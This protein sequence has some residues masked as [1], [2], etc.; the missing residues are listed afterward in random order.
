MTK[1]AIATLRE[2]FHYDP[3]TGLITWRLNVNSRARAG[4]EAGCVSKTSTKTYRRIRFQ[5]RNYYGHQV[6]FAL[7]TGQWSDLIDHRDH[8]GLNNAWGNLRDATVA[9]NQHNRTGLQLNN[10]S[11][12]HGASVTRGKF[13]LR[14]RAGGKRHRIGVFGT[15]E[16]ARHACVKARRELHAGFLE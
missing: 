15:A 5:G 13:D 1:P 16:E 12:V 10:T 9:M 11:G 7:T 14:I 8:N 4:D 2:F 3:T 6:A